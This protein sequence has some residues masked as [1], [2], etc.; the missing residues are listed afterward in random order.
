M[1]I[2][3]PVYE[4]MANELRAMWP[5]GEVSDEEHEIIKGA[6]KQLNLIVKGLFIFIFV[7]L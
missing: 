7:L 2:H 3:R 4:N 6:L 1:V 5:E